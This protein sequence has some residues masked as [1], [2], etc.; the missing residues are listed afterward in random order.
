[1]SPAT[2]QSVTADE[3]RKVL[4]ATDLESTVNDVYCASRAVY[5]L[6]ECVLGNEK[7]LNNKMDDDSTNA[8]VWAAGAVLTHR[9]RQRTRITAR[10]RMGRRHD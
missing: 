6:L 5:A 10:L 4:I 7:I 8:I 2:N 3:I 1:M 9:T